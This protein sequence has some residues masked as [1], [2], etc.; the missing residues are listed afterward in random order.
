M[1][2]KLPH[3]IPFPRNTDYR[4]SST[5]IFTSCIKSAAKNSIPTIKRRDDWVKDDI[6]DITI[7]RDELSQELLKSNTETNRDRFKDICYNAED[8][9]YDYRRGKWA[10]FCKTCIL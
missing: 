2:W 10:G 5:E 9:I 3:Q 1:R 4:E 7:E 8:Q 6:K